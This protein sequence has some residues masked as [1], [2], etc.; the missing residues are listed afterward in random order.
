MDVALQSTKK[1]PRSVSSSLERGLVPCGQARFSSA[2]LPRTQLDGQA[3]CEDRP[4]GVRIEPEVELGGRRDVANCVG[5]ATH[6][7]AT[8]H[9]GDDIWCLPHRQ[10]DVG[11]RSKCHQCAPGVGANGADQ[12]G[13]RVCGLGTSS[14][15]WISLV[16]QPVFSVEPGGVGRFHQQRSGASRVHGNARATQLGRVE[17]VACRLFDVAVSGDGGDGDDID[18]GI[19]QC[20]RQSDRIVGRRVGVDDHGGGHCPHTGR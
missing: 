19:A 3:C 8:P 4:G 11:Q 1:W 18:V 16:A 17:G 20:H 15:W 2:Q 13:H 6:D 14:R 12:S 5:G 9:V 10:G 7:H